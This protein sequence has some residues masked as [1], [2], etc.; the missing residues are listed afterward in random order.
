[1]GT[2]GRICQRLDCP[3]RAVSPLGRPLAVDEDSSTLVPYAVEDPGSGCRR[4]AGSGPVVP[5]RGYGGPTE[6]EPFGGPRVQRLNKQLPANL[7]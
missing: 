1:M 6:G 2:A 5:V 3:Q 7:G 4:T